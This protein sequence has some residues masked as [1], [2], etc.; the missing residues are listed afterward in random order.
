MDGKS[1]AGAEVF[2]PLRAS[3]QATPTSSPQRKNSVD[4][5]QNSPSP[6]RKQSVD[7]LNGG[8]PATSRK[9]TMDT[10]AVFERL[11]WDS[12][13][14]FLHGTISREEADAI[15]TLKQPVEEGR[16]LI[17]VRAPENKAFAYV[18]QKDRQGSFTLMRRDR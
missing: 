9:N 7:V 16:F 8:A 18:V 17:R 5:L 12:L 4:L 3:T 15:L 6:H 1:N 11:D 14:L 2:S 10:S 13:A